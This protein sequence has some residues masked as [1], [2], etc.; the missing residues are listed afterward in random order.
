MSL[1][2]YLLVTIRVILEGLVQGWP[3]TL[4]LLAALIFATANNSPFTRRDYRG[5]YLLILLPSLLT[6]LIMLF[7]GPSAAIAGIVLVLAHLPI[8]AFLARRFYEYQGIVLAAGAFQMW[9]SMVAV[10]MTSPYRLLTA[11]SLFD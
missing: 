11:Q 2:T 5:S 6:I 3:I 7:G 10:F 1:I 9:V 8:N 4:V